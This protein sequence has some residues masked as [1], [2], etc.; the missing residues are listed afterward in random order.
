MTVNEEVQKIL[1][2]IITTM[3]RVMRSVDTEAQIVTI[4]L[5]TLKVVGAFCGMDVPEQSEEDELAF[6]KINEE[7]SDKIWSV[8]KKNLE[9]VGSAL[10][11]DP[12]FDLANPAN[13]FRNGKVE[14]KV[15]F[16]MSPSDM[17]Q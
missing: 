3:T 15:V 17:V 1:N 6:I 2:D 4:Y 16:L 5:R 14:S 11:Y 7:T 12:R 8:F 9:R 10:V 13:G